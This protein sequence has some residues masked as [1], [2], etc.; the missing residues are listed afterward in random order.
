MKLAINFK[1]GSLKLRTQMFVYFGGSTLVIFLIIMS[2]VGTRIYRQAEKDGQEIAAQQAQ[3]LSLS[4]QKYIDHAFTISEGLKT[5]VV[6]MKKAGNP[7]REALYDIV[8][9]TVAMNDFILSIWPMFY[10]NQFDNNDQRYVNDSTYH[11]SEGAITYSHYKTLKGTIELEPGFLSDFEEEYFVVPAQK[12]HCTLLEPSEETYVG[13]DELHY[14]MS[15]VSPVVVHGKVAGVIG[16]DI[17]MKAVEAMVNESKIYQSGFAAVISHDFQL[18]TY[19]DT[20][21]ARKNMSK[22]LSDSS[23]ELQ[24][25]IQANQPYSYQCYS[26][27][28]KKDVVRY[29]KP[30]VL[31]ANNAPWAVMT[32]IP[33]DEIYADAYFFRN[34]CIALTLLAIVFLSVVTYFI[35]RSISKPVVAATRLAREIAQGHLIMAEIAI[36]RQDE[37]GQLNQ[38]LSSMAASLRNMIGMT[39]KSINAIGETS[40]M[41]SSE[42]L[43]LSNSTTE[44]ASAIEEISSSMEEMVASIQQNMHNSHQTEAIANKAV[45]SIREVAI[46]SHESL[47]SVRLITEKTRVVNDIAMQTNI[48]ALNAA[49]EAARAGQHG[50]GFAVVAAEVRKL[51][52]RS[53]L[54]ADEIAALS[55]STL[56][57]T[58]ESELKLLAIVPEIEKTAHLVQEISTSSRE[59]N[60]GADQINSSIQQFSYVTQQNSSTSEELATSSADLAKQSSQLKKVISYFKI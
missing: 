40:L 7:S 56:S 29:F 38:S 9:E 21:F 25:S 51:A 46:S 34:L 42:S 18:A 47:E 5:A 53:K 22:L 4:L 12:A 30:V 3:Q 28:L 37:I 43:S 2:I 50:R 17:E 10:P 13:D 39:Q 60:A 35:S 31:L 16:I 26:P 52:E 23:S 55:G 15:V 36:D 48:L 11:S 19:P 45:E 27:H 59:Q 24:K 41:L 58:E 49:V 1:K 44:Q 8:Y 14:S 33:V 32:E 6:G 57:I 20:S 54:A